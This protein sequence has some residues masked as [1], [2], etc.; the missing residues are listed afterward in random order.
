M[1]WDYVIIVMFVKL[2]FSVSLNFLHLQA[3][4]LVADMSFLFSPICLLIR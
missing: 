1:F 4:I 3:E 2:W